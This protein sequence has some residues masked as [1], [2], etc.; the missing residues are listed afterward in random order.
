MRNFIAFTVI[1]ICLIII[2]ALL[3]AFSEMDFSKDRNNKDKQ[4]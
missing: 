2:F 3:G 1:M 4:Q